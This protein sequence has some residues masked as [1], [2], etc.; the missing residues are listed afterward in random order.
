M[1][2]LEINKFYYLRGGSERHLFE[3][4]EALTRRGHEVVTFSMKDARNRPDASSDYFVDS[5]DL[6]KM[7]LKN[8]FKIFYNRQALHSLEKLIKQERPDIAHLHNIQYQ[9]TPAIIQTLKKHNI[10]VIQ[11]LH[12]YNIICPNAKLYTE[13]SPCERCSGSKFYQCLAHKCVHDSYAKSLLAMLEAYL[14]VSLFRRYEGVDR[15]IAP[16]RFMKEVSARCGLPEEK[17][18][19]LHNFID[20]EKFF[21]LKSHVGD[22]LLYF[23]RLAEE[24]GVDM[25]I[26]AVK[27]LPEEKLKIVGSGPESTNYQLRITNYKL[28]DRVELINHQSGKDLVNLIANAKAI[29]IPS[30]WPE[31][32]PY[33]LLE[34][35]SFGKAVVVARIGGLP[36]LIAHGKNGFL[37][38]P[39][40]PESLKE[41]LRILGKSDLDQIGSEARRSIIGLHAA[42]YCEYFEKL[43]IGLKK[44]YNS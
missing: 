17:I 7:S 23:G 35:M 29:I 25:L 3:L 24:K 41:Q 21:S 6:E 36:E 42:K 4:S 13:G 2:I 15:F 43:A 40:D 33:S 12:A 34:A 14:N 30:R 26:E 18:H 28:Q 11:T 16:S 38:T 19:V 31:N 10:P 5:V 32:M 37:F 44:D 9:L 20:S 22:Y 39:R 27:D 8:I 1:K